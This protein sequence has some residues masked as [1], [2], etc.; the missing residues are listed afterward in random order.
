M[1][2][3]FGVGSDDLNWTGDLG[4]SLSLLYLQAIQWGYGLN[5]DG[6]NLILDVC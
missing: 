3:I 2:E 1:S 5:I 6:I 4:V